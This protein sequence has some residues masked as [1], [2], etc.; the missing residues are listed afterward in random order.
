MGLGRMWG[1]RTW[2]CRA[3]NK[4]DADITASDVGASA[5]DM[6]DAAMRDVAGAGEGAGAAAGAGD[7]AS[8]CACS[9]SR[10]NGKQ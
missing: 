3:T 10:P 2:Q 9:L 1:A 6:R 8:G 4:D 5:T 7:T